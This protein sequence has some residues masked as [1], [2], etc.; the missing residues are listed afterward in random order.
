MALEFLRRAFGSITQPAERVAGR[1]TSS[2]GASSMH[3]FWQ[4]PAVPLVETSAVFE[5]LTPPDG[6]WLYFWA[7]QA[8]FQ[9]GSQPMGAGHFGL[10]HHP[11]YP[12]DGALNWGGYHHG[13][14][15]LPGSTSPLGS[16]VGNANTSNFQWEPRRKYRYRISR[17]PDRGWRG[18]IVDLQTGDETVA[19][20]L[21]VDATHLS[22][23]MVWSEVFAPCDGPTVAVAW[24]DLHGIDADGHR[25]NAESVRINYQSVGDGGCSNTSVTSRS[26]T[27]VQTTNEQRTQPTGKILT[28]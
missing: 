21:W 23:P 26:G 15:E 5:V 28:L 27:I 18:S 17:S 20:D 14:G 7:L 9:H 19:R 10:Q 12:A 8:S 13:G 11:E 22:N 16:A 4:V 1:P 2:N 25:V 3:A 24:S 6:P